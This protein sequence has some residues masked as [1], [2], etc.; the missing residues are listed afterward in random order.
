MLAESN[1]DQFHQYAVSLTKL[2][3]LDPM[4]MG[5]IYIVTQAEWSLHTQALYDSFRSSIFPFVNNFG[6]SAK[7][8]VGFLDRFEPTQNMGVMRACRAA[9]SV[10][11]SFPAL[12]P[13]FAPQ[14]RREVL[15][16]EN[17]QHFPSDLH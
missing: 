1:G 5:D 4:K 14:H 13:H 17:K 9:S 10:E 12:R 3:H 2:F 8:L 6:H 7:G 16:C 11:K 15:S